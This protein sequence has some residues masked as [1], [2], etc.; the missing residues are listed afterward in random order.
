MSNHFIEF[1]DSTTSKLPLECQK[2][3]IAKNKLEVFFCDHLEYLLN[4]DQIKTYNQVKKRNWLIYQLYIDEL[5]KIDHIINQGFEITLLKGICLVQDIY[6]DPSQR[7]LADIDLLLSPEEFVKMEEILLGLGYSKD[8]ED[9]WEANNFKTNF[10]KN[11]G[12]YE[13]VIELHSRLFFMQNGVSFKKKRVEGY[14]S[15]YELDREDMLIH[16][17]GHL[18][19][20]HTFISI[21]WL[22]DIYLF[23]LK[24]DQDLD[25]DYIKKSLEGLEQLNSARICLNSILAVFKLESKGLSYLRQSLFSKLAGLVMNSSFYL[26]TSDSYIRYYIVKHF[27]KDSLRE[28]LRYD[29]LWL[30]NRWAH[31]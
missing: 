31:E 2:H 1:L 5:K 30:K 19:Y 24:Y 26:S 28:A 25:W 17:M 8:I 29:Y 7:F 4:K 12:P 14:S 13:L 18:G 20:Q 6:Q 21:H 15:F 9:K 27:T 22:Y 16:L 10:R 3:F 23:L 11:I